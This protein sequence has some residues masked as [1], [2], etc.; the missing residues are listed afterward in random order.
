MANIPLH[1]FTHKHF[2]YLCTQYS[3]TYSVK[4]SESKTPDTEKSTTNRLKR[5]NDGTVISITDLDDDSDNVV[6]KENKPKPI[7]LK[8][9]KKEKVNHISQSVLHSCYT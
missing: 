7:P 1:F 5:L 3:S 6:E 4:N 9:I 8:Q 2:N